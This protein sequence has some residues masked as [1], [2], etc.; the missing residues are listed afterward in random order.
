MKPENH[1][2]SDPIAVVEAQFDQLKGKILENEPNEDCHPDRLMEVIKP[3]LA[4][5]ATRR[6]FPLEDLPSKAANDL[7]VACDERKP[8]LS[9]IHR[10]ENLELQLHRGQAEAT[11]LLRDG[12]HAI[13]RDES[14]PAETREALEYY[15][16]SGGIYVEMEFE[17]LAEIYALR[18]LKLAAENGNLP[19]VLADDVEKF[20]ESRF[21]SGLLKKL[22]EIIHDR[23][24]ENGAS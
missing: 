1:L 11:I 21:E 5:A 18:Q 7:V 20:V 19:N 17:W 22:A 9:L 12:R 3:I 10:L 8:G 2:Q 15:E 23:F 13:L 6:S 4:D 16:Q 14:G 24:G